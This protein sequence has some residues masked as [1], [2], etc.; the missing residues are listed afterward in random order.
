MSNPI[1]NDILGV[2][3]S[4]LTTNALLASTQV[5]KSWQLFADQPAVW[6]AH[7]KQQNIPVVKG[8]NRNYKTDFRVLHKI[9]IGYNQLGPIFGKCIGKMPKIAQKVF[10]LLQQPDPFEPEKTIGKTCVFVIVPK[11][12]KRAFEEGLLNDLAISGDGFKKIDLAKAKQDHMEIPCSNKNIFLL[13][14]HPLKEGMG[15]VFHGNPEALDK[16]NAIANDVHIYLMRKYTP[17]QTCQLHRD[18][19]EALL[20]TCGF[21]MVPLNVR[22]LANA[23]EIAETERCSDRDPNVREVR[24]ADVI[25]NPHEV[26]ATIGN[27]IIDR[28]LIIN[29][30]HCVPR[31]SGLSIGAVPCILADAEGQ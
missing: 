14:N 13:A 5:S 10:D 3:F 30:Q 7:S 2:I 17:K 15:K 1:H 18:V 20:K 16:C 22:M 4:Q 26:N 19:Q 12:F 31:V 29:T 23:V 21:Q 27:F 11:L 8:E 6:E 28:G 25:K 24:T 9:T